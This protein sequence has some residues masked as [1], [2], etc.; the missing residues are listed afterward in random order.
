DKIPLTSNGKIDKKSL[1]TPD[2]NSLVN[3]DYEAPRNESEKILAKVWM[4][5]LGIDRI[6][7]NDNFFDLGGHSLKATILVSKINK[8]LNMDINIKDLFNNPTIKKISELCDNKEKVIFRSIEVCEQK[9]FYKTSAAQKRMYIMQKLDRSTAYNMPMMFKFKGTFN[10]EKVNE[11]FNK[12]MMRNHSLKTTFHEV[13][14]EIVQKVNNKYKFNINIEDSTGR[15]LD[16]IF[17][18]FVIE[19]DLNVGPLFRVKAIKNYDE[20][21]LLIDMHHIISDGV[22]L[23]IL[24]K[25]FTK[26][27]ND[28]DLEKLRIQYKDFSVWQNNILKSKEIKKEEEYWINQFSGEIPILDL[29]YDYERSSI[30]SFIGNNI[31]VSLDKNITERLRKVSMENGITMHMLLLTVYNV[32]LFK[33]SGQDEIVVGIP[34][35]GRNHVDLQEVIGVFVN[36]LAIKTNLDINESFNVLLKKVRGILLDSYRNQNYQFEELINKVNLKRDN[37]RNPLFDV[38]FNMSN[39]ET[40]NSSTQYDSYL[41]QV[42]KEVNSSKYDITLNVIDDNDEIKIK[43]EYCTKLFKESTIDR[44]IK[45]YINILEIICLDV[46][47]KVSE[48]NIITEEEKILI[49]EFNNTKLDYV[50]EKTIKELFEDQ[51]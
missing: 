6:G 42:N 26:I 16:K 19:F 3:D 8:K 33:Y 44:M 28:V 12:L 40:N 27:Y 2:I 14:N 51:V 43:F 32:L 37:S 36:I 30:K 9:G 23:R 38:M 35:A 45:H 24:L 21:Y 46:K 5:I 15:D 10:I 47:I 31:E 50:K 13:N 41:E 20:Y 4:D 49:D 7:I 29:P 48:I 34:I 39:A 22:S 17:N 11:T 1:K 25:E 18:D